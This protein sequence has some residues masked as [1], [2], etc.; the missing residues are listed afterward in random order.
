MGNITLETEKGIA[1]SVISI[2]SVLTSVLLLYFI[3]TVILQYCKRCKKTKQYKFLV[4]P[5]YITPRRICHFGI[6]CYVLCQINFIAWEIYYYSFTLLTDNFNSL[7]Y[8]HWYEMS[9]L[10][11]TTTFGLMIM[12][13]VIAL[14]L[15]LGSMVTQEKSILLK[16]F[17]ISWTL[18]IATLLIDS[19]VHFVSLV[20]VMFI[21]SDLFYDLF[22]VYF[23]IRTIYT[24]AGL[25]FV[26]FFVLLCFV[27]MLVFMY[28]IFRVYNAR[29][30][31]EIKIRTS[32]CGG[33][34]ALC[35]LL[36][37]CM[38]FTHV[39]QYFNEFSTPRE[40]KKP[41]DESHF[42]IGWADIPLIIGLKF[43]PSFL[44]I[45]MMNKPQLC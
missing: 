32:I 4:Q 1:V 45:L 42:L 41:G 7:I 14:R 5:P 15:Q 31:R 44:I 34:I 26:L 27:L 11:D 24:N 25:F 33:L 28:R 16:I 9:N 12:L 10:L 39:V 22:E 30:S 20:Y 40:E 36:R 3:C 17:D 2:S 43:L 35:I 29:E 19:L 8:I 18:G 21:P 6:F 38:C 13:T 37:F 23:K